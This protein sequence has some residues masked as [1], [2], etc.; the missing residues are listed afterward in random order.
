M[1]AYVIVDIAV[2]DL[3][4]FAEYQKARGRS[5]RSTGA[6][7]SLPDH[8][9]PHWRATASQGHD[10]HRVPKPRTSEAV[11]RRTRVSGTE[12]T[13]TEDGHL[14]RAPR[15]GPNVGAATQVSRF[16]SPVSQDP[17]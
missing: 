14:S 11:V 10:R 8:L 1:A 4:G 15:R 2:T 9:P 7:C 13:P 5:W 6:D 12:T 16:R 3:A 17:A